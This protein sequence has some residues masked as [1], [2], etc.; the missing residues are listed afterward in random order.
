VENSK[1]LRAPPARRRMLRRSSTD[2]ERRL[3]QC[4][5]ARQL[6]GAKF[7]RQ[8]A[9]GPYVLDF[10]SP[11]HRLAVEVDGSSH[12]S[13]EGQ[14]RDDVRTAY[15]QSQGVR[16]LRFTNIE[17]LAA[18]DAVQERVLRAIIDD[19]SPQPS[20]RARGEGVPTNSRDADSF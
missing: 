1:P 9:L 7:R 2:A 16:V 6:A 13:P 4:L 19:P 5:R 8:H 11:Q 17:V 15:L 14:L 3:W 20:P 12:L 18:T 10:Y